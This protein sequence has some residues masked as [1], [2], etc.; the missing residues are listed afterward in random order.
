MVL[1][2]LLFHPTLQ[3]SLVSSSAVSRSVAV[4]V[5]V[6]VSGPV[7]SSEVSMPIESWQVIKVPVDPLSDH[8]SKM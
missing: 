4:L 3:A 5:L 1:A 6:C 7:E 2:G 8:A